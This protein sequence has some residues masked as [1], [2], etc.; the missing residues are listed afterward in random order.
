MYDSLLGQIDPN[1]P[2]ILLIGLIIV[3]GIGG[4]YGYITSKPKKQPLSEEQ[5]HL[6]ASRISHSHNLK[7]LYNRITSIRAEKNIQTNLIFTVTPSMTYD[8]NESTGLE[9]T[10]KRI[11][12][13]DDQ[14]K[15]SWTPITIM[16]DIQYV[17]QHLE[18][19][20]YTSINKLWK[21]ANKLLEKY[22]KNNDKKT[23]IKID[24]TLQTFRQELL[25][26]VDRLNNDHIMKGKWDICP[27]ITF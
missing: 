24:E 10:R 22:N 26:L 7:K 18:D 16:T 8:P 4:I 12:E 9:E 21:K 20:E 6:I 14:L 23:K 2:D 1:L 19:K 25:T 27:W 15:G 17:L 3:G 13:R 5:K 11:S